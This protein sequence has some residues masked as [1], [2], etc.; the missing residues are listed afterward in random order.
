MKIS[1]VC[2][3][4]GVTL[5]K[6]NGSASVLQ[7]SQSFTHRPKIRRISFNRKGA[8]LMKKKTRNFIFK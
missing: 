4:R 5:G 8:E 6:Y 3:D 1:Y 2:S 7:S